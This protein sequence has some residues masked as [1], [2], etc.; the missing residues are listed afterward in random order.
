MDEFKPLRCGRSGHTVASCQYQFQE[1]DL[2]QI[3][4]YVC[5]VKGHLCCAKQDEAS[6]VHKEAPSCCR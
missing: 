3:H 2:K 1:Q 4:C 5:G 6:G